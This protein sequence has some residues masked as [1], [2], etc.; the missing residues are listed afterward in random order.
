LKAV[1]AN[2][3]FVQVLTFFLPNVKKIKDVFQ[4]LFVSRV[5]EKV[6]TI[7]NRKKFS[8]LLF[9]KFLF[10]VN[11]LISIYKQQFLNEM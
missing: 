11:W 6:L 8:Q 5:E 2:L 1:K 7:R 10:L 4:Q 3:E 9:Y